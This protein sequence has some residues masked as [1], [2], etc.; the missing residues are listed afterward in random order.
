M[1]KN[2]KRAESPVDTL[3]TRIVFSTKGLRQKS[4][5]H[6]RSILSNIC[7]PTSQVKPGPYEQ[8]RFNMPPL[9]R[10]KTMEYS[11]DHQ[12]SMRSSSFSMSK[13]K[14][15]VGDYSEIVQDSIALSKIGEKE[16]GQAKYRLIY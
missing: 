1:S 15:R 12:G 14:N 10:L 3:M 8:S 6:S 13:A 7:E 16:E 4:N 2:R 11:K 5:D 9:E